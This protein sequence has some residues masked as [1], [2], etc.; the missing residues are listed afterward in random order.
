MLWI[1]LS[2]MNTMENH[3]FAPLQWWR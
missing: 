3:R 1:K 2:T